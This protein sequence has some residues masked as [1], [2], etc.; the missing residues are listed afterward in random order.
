MMS[1]ANDFFDFPDSYSLVEQIQDEHSDFDSEN[2]VPTLFS[3]SP[4]YNDESF[5]NLME[6]KKHSFKI[7]SLNCQS[8]NAKFNELKIYL[9]HFRNNGITISVICLQETWINDD[10]NTSLLKLEGYN[11]IHK[12]KHC[13]A[14]GGVAIYVHESFR[15][16]IISIQQSQ[17]WDGMFIEIFENESCTS[18]IGQNK[19]IIGN[20]YR[21]PRTNVDC[22][23]IF[24]KEITDVLEGFQFSKNVVLA[25]DYNINLLKFKEN[26]N[27]NSFLENMISF[28]YIPKISFPTRLTHRHGTL[29]DNFFVK[30]ANNFS[31]TTSGILVKN[32][33]DHLPYFVTLDYINCHKES[34]KYIKTMSHF[35]INFVNFLRNSNIVEQLNSDISSDPNVSY[36]KLQN[37]L[38]I[39]LDEYFPVKT[40]RFNKYIHKKCS[41]ITKGI[42]ISIKYRDKLYSSLKCLSPNNHLYQSKKTN[43]QTY[44]RILRQ[45]IRNA[46]KIYYFKCFERFKNDM[47]KTWSMIKEVINKSKNKQDFPKYFLINEEQISDPLTI[48]NRFNE[49]FVN[50]GPN[51]ANRITAPSN[52]S[53]KDYL[54]DDIRT[55]FRF[56]VVTNVE[57]SKAIDSLKPKTS[58]GEDRLS[59]KLLKY[60]K[61]EI[62]DSLTLIFNQ[63]V[64]NNMFPNALKIAKVVPLHKKDEVYIFDNYRPISLLPSISK[65]FEKLMHKQIC[66]YF[67]ENN[68]FYNS[69]YGF[70]N[71]HSTELAAIELID[72]ILMDLDN[73]NIP[74]SIFLDLSKAFD[75][76]D[77][78]ILIYKLQY[79]G[80]ENSAI[81]L[82]KSYLLDRLQFVNF[83]EVNSCKLKLKTGVP[84]GSV[85]GPLF[86]IVYVNDLCKAS[87]L[88][89]PTIYAD[90]TTLSATLNTFQCDEISRDDAINA[91][92][93]K[94]S[95]WMKINKLSLNCNKSKA[96]L[97]RMPQKIVQLPCIRIDGVNLE[98]VKQFNF[99]GIMI[100]ENL[101]WKSHELLISKKISKTIG[102][103]NNLKSFLPT[104]IL[105]NI[106]NSLILPYLSYGAILWEKRANRLLALQKKAIRAVTNSK[107]NAHTEPLFKNLRLLKCS[108]LCA[109]QCYKFCFKLENRLLP[110][111]FIQNDLFIKNASIHSYSTARGNNYYIPR[112]R[113]DFA[114]SAIKYKIPMFFNAMKGEI[115]NKCYTHSMVSFKKYVKEK[116]L[117][118]Y[119]SECTIVNCYICRN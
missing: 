4:Y 12:G 114:K 115:K 61:N 50:I 29:I 67:M 102:I 69:Q 9:E 63:C 80:F 49:Y 70:R 93:S 15:F 41:W 75:T 28:G 82:V 6:S 36:E 64:T 106:Y 32:I 113:H 88:F 25:G 51:L 68:L 81:H 89:H 59:N 109:L 21:P 13:S 91:E 119:V 103:L 60:I 43:L 14:H 74:I 117:E 58:F 5:V 7:I 62:V 20:I 52:T 76:I 104:R 96:M 54:T 48:A 101:S 53:Y 73:G 99:L 24:M 23:E 10:Y 84:Q 98:F 105:L 40:C 94:V 90:D 86:F 16:N 111:Y 112:I 85:L 107:Y 39:G 22:I 1:L 100:D 38:K 77:Y 83:N 56:S 66:S 44:N 92:L 110:M 8:I 31:K 46:K 3:H 95:N 45:S 108:D 27:I 65:V 26:R 57:V 11:L 17:L 78:D 19:V 118:T 2:E 116:I 79:Y 71:M 30:I 47:K 18:A 35:S 97:F 72:R 42:L 55:S 87:T 33:S 34:I 37:I